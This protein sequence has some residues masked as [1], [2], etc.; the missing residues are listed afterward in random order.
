MNF[1]KPYTIVCSFWAVTLFV[2][3]LKRSLVS[4]LISI[5]VSTIAKCRQL[6]NCIRFG[7]LLVAEAWG[8]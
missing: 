2:L 5:Q 3:F 8:P 1:G 7:Y 6:V 4:P